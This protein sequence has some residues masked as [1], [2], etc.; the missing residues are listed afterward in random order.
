MFCRNVQKWIYKLDHDYTWNCGRLIGEDMLFRDQKGKVRV[1]LKKDGDIRITAGYA[2]DGCSPKLCVLDVLI[3]IPDGAV[4]SG[5]GKPKTYYATLV[6]DAL[7]QFRPK[8]IPFTRKE[9]DQFFFRLMAE[10][11]F[12]LRHIYYMAV[13][14][15]GS[16]AHWL[17]VNFGKKRMTAKADN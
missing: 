11:G 13:R 12:A 4:D 2:W 5:S 3:G 6:H 17:S 7:Y 1:V 8:G 14:L 16:H 10:T 9:I 15:F